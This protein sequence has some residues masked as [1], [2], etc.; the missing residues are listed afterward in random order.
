MDGLAGRTQGPG[1]RMSPKGY[2]RAPAHRSHPALQA[3]CSWKS[4][5]QEL[6]GA[7]ASARPC[8]EQGWHLPGAERAAWPRSI[9][10]ERR[11]GDK[12]A[13]AVGHVTGGFCGEAKYVPKA[14]V[15]E[16]A[17][18]WSSRRAAAA[19]SSAPQRA[20]DE[21]GRLLWLAALLC[22]KERL[23]GCLG[24]LQRAAQ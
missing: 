6:A 22:P 9:H 21:A 3:H 15:Q 19:R 24:G 8:P 16:E 5:E 12:H 18:T 4:N 13:A 17:K 10:P 11:Q 1:H 14:G 2:R 23:P 20:G 7:E